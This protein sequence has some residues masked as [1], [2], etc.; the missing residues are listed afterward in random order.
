[1]S[2]LCYIAEQLTPD[3]IAKWKEI[4]GFEFSS[5]YKS[6]RFLPSQ[7]FCSYCGYAQKHS[8]TEIFCDL[9]GRIFDRNSKCPIED[10]K[11][12]K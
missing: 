6:L 9:S 4:F 2:T 7:E 10:T 3:A 11:E 8:E 1:M 12:A 5:L